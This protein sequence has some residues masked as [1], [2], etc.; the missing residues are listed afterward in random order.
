[1]IAKAEAAAKTVD[2]VAREGSEFRAEVILASAGIDGLVDV[3]DRSIPATWVGRGARTFG[4]TGSAKKSDIKM[5]VRDGF[6]P[7]GTVVRSPQVKNTSFNF[8][9]SAPKTISCLLAHPNSDVKAAVDEAMRAGTAAAMDVFE[10]FARSRISAGGKSLLSVV[11][12]EIIA[13]VW[14]HHCSSTGDPHAHAH[15]MISATAP[16]ADGKWRAIDATLFLDVKRE[17]DAAAQFAIEKSISVA[18]GLSDADLTPIREAGSVRY[19]EIKSLEKF[20]EP[21]SGARGHIKAILEKS[22]K[23]LGKITHAEDLAAWHEH[24]QDKNLLAEKIEHEID[25]ALAEGGDAAAAIHRMWDKSCDYELFNALKNF[26]I[27]KNPAPQGRPVDLRSSLTRHENFEKEIDILSKSEKSIIEKMREGAAESSKI[28]ARIASERKSLLKFLPI[29]AGRREIRLRDD[30]AHLAAVTRDL[31]SLRARLTEIRGKIDNLQKDHY[32]WEN[33][34]KKYLT[35]LDGL[36]GWKMA[37]FSAAIIGEIGCDVAESR[38][39]AARL[40]D[41]WAE[42]GL[43]KSPMPGKITPLIEAIMAGEE[44]PPEKIYALMGS[45]A[46]FITT[47]ALKAEDDFS[48]KITNFTRIQCRRLKIDSAGLS[49]DQARA[50]EKI[51]LGRK[52]LPISGVAGAGKSFL[53]TRVADAARAEGLPVFA[54]ARN[55]KRAS[56]TG[57]DIGADESFSI[58]ALKKSLTAE[59]RR[60]GGLLVID[61]AALIDGENWGEIAEILE[62]SNFQIVAIGDRYQAQSIDRKGIWHIAHQAAGTH[63]ANLFS[64]RRCQ[65]WHAEHDFLRN[66]GADFLPIAEKE[67]RILPKIAAAAPGWIAQKILDTPGAIAVTATNAEAAEISAAVQKKMEIVGKIPCRYACKIGIGDKIRTRKNERSLFVT[68]GDEFL[69]EKIHADGSVRAKSMKNPSKSVTLPPAYLA[70]AAELAYASTI[71]S[72][73]GIT[74][75]QAIVC[76]TGAMG[77]SAL[78]SGATRGTEAPIYLMIGATTMEEAAAALTATLARDDIA[79]SLR[80]I[81]EKADFLRESQKADEPAPA[82][83]TASQRAARAAPPP[84]LP[85]DLPSRLAAIRAREAERKAR[86]RAAVTATSGQDR[87]PEMAPRPRF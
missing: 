34:E 49:P 64:S 41:R 16:C 25:A 61:E 79:T 32:I 65:K 20:I 54:T 23:I 53:M 28:S 36:H 1:M 22:G 29:A 2:W 72:A 58:A 69:V 10:R 5:L 56:E 81:G 13:A 43:I 62:K 66:G 8:I 15:L 75:P 77:R 47:A 27:S 68:N 80:E 12:P 3:L 26:K 21:L 35:Y 11:T 7:D 60:R 51:A 59:K 83:V 55:R 33:L 44:M 9:I 45:K 31:A 85:L 73:Q 14:P 57:D 6:L 86:Q 71:D 74:I 52:F 78:Y 46:R 24:R 18:L 84:P 19:R 40:L 67:G 30:A 50:A 37:D 4:L 82:A 63:S 76:V 42:K 17:A 38:I 70:E 39:I 48:E 87:A